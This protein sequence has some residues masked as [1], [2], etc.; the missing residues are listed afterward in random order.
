M[1]RA[2]CGVLRNGEDERQQNVAHVEVVEYSEQGILKT[3]AAP[4][5]GRPL[6]TK[7][8]LAWSWPLAAS[9]TEHTA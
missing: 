9:T 5:R 4:S 1:P 2:A 8:W 7:N 6:R 3:W